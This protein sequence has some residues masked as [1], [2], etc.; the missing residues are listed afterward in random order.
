MPIVKDPK[1]VE[2][3]YD[4][5]RERNT[6]LPGFCTE[7]F[8]T[9]ETI[10]RVMHQ[11]GLDYGIKF[12]PAIISFTASYPYRPQSINYTL[13]RDSFWGFKAI[14]DDIRLFMSDES[15]YRNIRLMV[16]LDHAQPESDRKILKEEL[17][18]LATVMFDCSTFP[19]EENIKRTAQFVEQTKNLVRVEGA[20]DEISVTGKTKL[21]ELTSVEMADKFVRETGAYLIVPNLGTEQQ[22]TE[23]KAHYSSERARE[24]SQRVGKKLVLHGS[25]CLT[26]RDLENLVKDGIIRTNIWTALEKTGGQAVANFF[27]RELGNILDERQIRILQKEGFLGNQYSKNNYVDR[28]CGNKLVPK[29]EMITQKKRTE[30]W[31]RAVENKIRFYLDILGYR[32]LTT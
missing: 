22:S 30:I 10:L 2:E 9:T 31:T 19:F 21:S 26:E 7:N 29:V 8:Q 4:W 14:M 25:S 17:D 28:V 15:P 11:V 23:N 18:D 16:H 6:C 32:N 27:I 1:E 13:L 5:L 3:I 12:P 24:I 20:V